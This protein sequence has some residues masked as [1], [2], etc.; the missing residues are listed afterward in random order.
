[1]AAL[2]VDSDAAFVA[3]AV[4]L[5]RDPRALADARAELARRRVD[6]GLFDMPGFA[7]DFVAAIRTMLA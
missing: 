4:E 1:M 7:R 5:G 3:R 6:S 2:N